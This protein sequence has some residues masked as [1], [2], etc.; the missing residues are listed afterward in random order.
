MAKPNTTETPDPQMTLAQ[1]IARLSEEVGN[2]LGSGINRKAIVILLH[3]STKI[4]QRT[5]TTLLDELPRL[6]A[7]Y[8][9]PEGLPSKRKA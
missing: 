5:I 6:H 2:L 7:R 9:E 3:A 4:P 1:N 8:C